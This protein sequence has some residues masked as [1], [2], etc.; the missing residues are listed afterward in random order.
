MAGQ[1][2]LD[3]LA[4]RFQPVEGFELLAKT[5]AGSVSNISTHRC[6]DGGRTGPLVRS[7]PVLGV[8]LEPRFDIFSAV[9]DHGA[10][11]DRPR[12]RVAPVAAG[13]R[14]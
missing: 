1:H 5:W 7:F 13:G 9:T 11:G 3:D 2:H 12:E 4:G 8:L 10:Q 6:G 14:C